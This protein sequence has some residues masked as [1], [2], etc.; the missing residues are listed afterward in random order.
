MEPNT[1]THTHT[2]C[3]DLIDCYSIHPFIH[4]FIHLLGQ[5][6]R[7]RTN[8]YDDD[9]DGNGIMVMVIISMEI[10]GKQKKTNYIYTI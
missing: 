5:E 8:L 3:T 4:S 10:T 6:R 9:D 7:W 1:N 2:V